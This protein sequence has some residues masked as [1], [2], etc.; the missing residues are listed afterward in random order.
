MKDTINF[1]KQWVNF[2]LLPPYAEL[3]QRGGQG[4]LAHLP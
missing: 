1:R 3:I 4:G 2:I